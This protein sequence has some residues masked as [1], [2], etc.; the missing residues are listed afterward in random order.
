MKKIGIVTLYG[1]FNYGNRL[2]NY[3]VQKLLSKYGNVETIMNCYKR[4]KWKIIPY[5]IKKLIKFFI[6]PY[7]GIKAI[8]R[9]RNF[10]K[11]SQ[12]ITRT[13]KYQNIKKVNKKLNKS[14]DYFFTGSDQVWNHQYKIEPFFL[15][16]FADNNKKNSISASISRENIEETAKINAKKSWMTYN[17]ISVRENS[18]KKLIEGEVA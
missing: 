8:I 15:L 14:Y 2:Q 10:K 7:N 5:Y 3:A 6:N 17:A 1:E 13:K 11:F 16:D 12:Y 18:S 4:P 9:K